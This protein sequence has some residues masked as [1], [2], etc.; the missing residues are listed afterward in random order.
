[1]G[2]R[3]R[4]G[5]RPAALRLLPQAVPTNRVRNVSS[6]IG[7]LDADG[8]AALESRWC[9]R[10]TEATVLAEIGVS[11]DVLLVDGSYWSFTF[12]DPTELLSYVAHEDAEVFAAVS[13]LWQRGPITEATPLNIIDGADEAWLINVSSRPAVNP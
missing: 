6:A 1:M 2:K 7:H 3:A 10:A 8:R 11:K 9:L 13:V 4:L 12:A 5:Q